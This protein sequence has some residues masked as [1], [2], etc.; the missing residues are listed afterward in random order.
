ML[1]KILAYSIARPVPGKQELVFAAI[2][3]GESG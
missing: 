1:I 2:K 3:T